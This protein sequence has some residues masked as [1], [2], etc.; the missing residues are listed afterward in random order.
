M[1]WQADGID[2]HRPGEQ[3]GKHTTAVAERKRL[4]V[5]VRCGRPQPL[6]D[7]E[8]RIGRLVGAADK[9]CMSVEAQAARKRSSKDGKGWNRTRK[10][11]G[12]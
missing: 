10:L 9:T 1:E 12:G 2:G 7:S 3:D 5:G 11:E 8:Q 4:D 6:Y